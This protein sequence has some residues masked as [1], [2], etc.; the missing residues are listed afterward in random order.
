MSLKC[1]LHCVSV[2]TIDKAVSD[3][4]AAAE[5]E[6]PSCCSWSIL[7]FSSSSSSS[8]SFSPSACGISRLT[9]SA[10]A[11][12]TGC[13]SASKPSCCSLSG[14]TSC[15][16]SHSAEIAARMAL[17]LDFG[18]KSLIRSSPRTPSWQ[19]CNNSL[20]WW[21]NNL[22]VCIIYALHAASFCV[23]MC[24][25]P[26]AGL[27]ASSELIPGPVSQVIACR[28]ASVAVVA[29]R[30]ILDRCLARPLGTEK[31]VSVVAGKDN[32]LLLSC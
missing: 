2:V 16:T 13:C 3:N 32:S 5:D 9:S 11:E 31:D 26:F 7:S 27:R 18:K 12:R 30:M 15:T 14:Y 21:N 22:V 23:Q 8:P 28:I 6:A 29:V 20:R 1:A 19:P 4:A 10:T 25:Y 17:Q 24:L